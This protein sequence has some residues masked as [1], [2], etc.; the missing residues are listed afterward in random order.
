MFY[1]IYSSFEVCLRRCMYACE[2]ASNPVIGLPM[3]FKHL[4]CNF[5]S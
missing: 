3:E 5:W 1:L 2:M 4:V